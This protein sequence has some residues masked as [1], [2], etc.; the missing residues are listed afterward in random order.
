MERHG[1]QSLKTLYRRN[2]LMKYHSVG[3]P[4]ILLAEDD[5]NDA[6]GIELACQSNGNSDH[7]RRVSSGQEAVEYL[8]G[9]GCY[10]DRSLYPLPTLILLDWRMPDVSGLEVLRWVR[11]H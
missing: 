11:K 8:S 6:F 2:R 10:R 3:V 9:N 5:D 7:F 4:F 1:W